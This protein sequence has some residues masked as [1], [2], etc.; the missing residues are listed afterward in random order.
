MNGIRIKDVTR[1][2]AAFEI[3]GNNLDRLE[4]E[5]RNGKALVNPVHLRE[6]MNMLG[7]ML[8][9]LRDMRKR[10]RDDKP[11]KIDTIKSYVDVAPFMQAC[12]VDLTRNGR[13][14]KVTA[15]ST[16]IAK[17][18]HFSL[19][20]VKTSGNASAAARAVIS[21][22]SSSSLIGLTFQ[23]LLQNL[24]PIFLVVNLIVVQQKSWLI[25]NP[26]NTNL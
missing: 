3:S 14:L 23:K 13:G 8:F 11:R 25:K 20:P 4:Q 15:P 21:L 24:Q 17:L 1:G 19:P 5:Y 18:H 22:S 9:D 10:K 26:K 16:K 7:D 2:I 12:G 6:S